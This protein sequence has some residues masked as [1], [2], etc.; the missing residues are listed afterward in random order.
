MVV[1]SQHQA[2]HAVPWPRL[3][4]KAS[5]DAGAHRASRISSTAAK[6]MDLAC[7]KQSCKLEEARSRTTWGKSEQPTKASALGVLP[8]Q[9]CTGVALAT[10]D[11]PASS[12]A[13]QSI[14]ASS[15]RRW[16]TRSISS[17][18]SVPARRD[19]APPGNFEYLGHRHRRRHCVAAPKPR[20]KSTESL[21]AHQ[22]HCR[23]RSKG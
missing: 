10:K 6:A 18:N 23:C 8:T 11:S 16:P 9:T 1:K 14:S 5:C 20:S 7:R 22:N 17:A 21:S 4:Q 19:H 12:H 15:N 3:Q 13:G 2:W